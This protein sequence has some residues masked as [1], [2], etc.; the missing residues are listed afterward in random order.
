MTWDV[1]DMQDGKNLTGS[2]EVNGKNVKILNKNLLGLKDVV[3]ELR[4][5]SI[6]VS[7]VVDDSVASLI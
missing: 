2:M 1:I 5:S 6:K 7:D 4:N 3:V